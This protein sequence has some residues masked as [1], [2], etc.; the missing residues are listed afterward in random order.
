MAIN[1]YMRVSTCIKSNVGRGSYHRRRNVWWV[2][3]WMNMT[4]CATQQYAKRQLSYVPRTL[5]YDNVDCGSG[6]LGRGY[7]MRYAA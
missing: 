2:L 6:W 7:H 1:I 5:A 4:K 3:W